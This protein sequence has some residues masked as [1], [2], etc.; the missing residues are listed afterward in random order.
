MHGR[1]R[2]CIG[3][4]IAS[5]W[6]QRRSDNRGKGLKDREAL[7]RWRWI[8]GKVI[9]FPQEFLLASSHTL[10]CVCIA[11]VHGA[12]HMRLCLAECAQPRWYH[13]RRP[14]RGAPACPHGSPAF[15][16]AASPRCCWAE[17]EQELFRFSPPGYILGK[18]STQPEFS[19]GHFFWAFI[20][21]YF[22]FFESYVLWVED[23]GL[24]ISFSTLK[25]SVHNL[26]VCIVS[27][28]KSALIL[29]FA[30]Y[31]WQILIRR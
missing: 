3:G 20:P 16:E 27:E 1:K 4:K 17:T 12:L 15:A 5:K 11:G 29:A 9:Y 2:F 30:W 19:A 18:I 10:V 22:F 8:G 25:M 6:F 26:L 24:I 14:T 31:L 21:P 13:G 28:D 7:A 23:F